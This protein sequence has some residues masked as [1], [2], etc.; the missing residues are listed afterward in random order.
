MKRA[1]GL[2]EGVQVLGAMTPEY[3]EILTFDALSFLAKLHRGCDARRRELLDRRAARQLE[4]EAGKLLDFL[5][6]TR[7]IR[8][9]DW[10]VAPVPADA[11][12][13]MSM[14]ASVTDWP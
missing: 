12:I 13:S 10:N 2:P 7:G 8:Q 6:D 3:A 4:L 5:P 14:H 11:V 1:Q 9:A